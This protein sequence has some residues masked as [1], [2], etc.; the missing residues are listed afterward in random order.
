M[1]LHFSP[2]RGDDDL[3]LELSAQLVQASAQANLSCVKEKGKGKDKSNGN[4]KDR[5]PVRSSHLS[6]EDRRRRLIEVKAK[7]RM[8]CLWSTGT[9]GK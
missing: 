7:N 2:T 8:S 5:H 6:L 9:L 1:Q 3:D 4:G